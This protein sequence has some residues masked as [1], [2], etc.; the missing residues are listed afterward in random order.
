MSR[1]IPEDVSVLQICSSFN[2]YVYPLTSTMRLIK[3]IMF[4]HFVHADRLSG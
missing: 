4:V 2:M 1:Y 3:V